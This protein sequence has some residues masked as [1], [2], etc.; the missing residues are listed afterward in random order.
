MYSS[1]F[2]KQHPVLTFYVVTFAVS[3]GG[4]LIAVRLGGM[5]RDPVQLAQMIPVMV[6]AMLAGPAVASILLTGIASGR[7]GYC[8]LVSHLISWRVRIGWYAAALLTAPLVLMT[9][10]LALSL[11]FPNFIPRILTESNK[12]SLLLMGFVVGTLAG[13]FEELGWTGFVIPKLRL[14]FDAFRTGA[15]VGLLWGA[16]HLPVNICSCVTP[17]GALSVP[18]F[19]GTVLFSIG[20]LPAYR[21]LMVRVWDHTG[22]LLVAMLMHFSLTASNIILGPA[23]T[24]GMMAPITF[25]L[26]LAAAMWIVAAASAPAGRKRQHPPVH[27]LRA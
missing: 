21:I 16:W 9:I 24:P 15:L 7:A 27:V 2:L 26:I 12:G 18:G 20:L 1:I 6:V 17:S 22:S 8:D 11:R 5:P 14:R 4:I 25:N 3:W 23:A 19:L 10:P 13:F